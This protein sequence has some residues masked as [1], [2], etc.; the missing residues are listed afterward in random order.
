MLIKQEVVLIENNIMDVGLFIF[1]IKVA[2]C[3]CVGKGVAEKIVF[4]FK[5]MWCE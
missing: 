5:F 4:R 3:I 2:C 1:S